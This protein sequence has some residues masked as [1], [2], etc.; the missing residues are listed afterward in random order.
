[1]Q[2]FFSIRLKKQRTSF[3]GH[4]PHFCSSLNIFV[5]FFNNLEFWCRNPFRDFIHSA[6]IH[7]SQA[8]LK[9]AT[10]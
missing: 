8:A 2:F 1:M 10:G 6:Q 5:I 4:L 3:W 9:Q 7:R